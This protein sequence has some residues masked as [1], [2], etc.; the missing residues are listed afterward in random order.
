[1]KVFIHLTGGFLPDDRRRR[2]ALRLTVQ[3]NVAIPLDAH[4]DWLDDPSGWHCNVREIRF[5]QIRHGCQFSTYRVL[6]Y[7]SL[8]I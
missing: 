7:W 6:L 2:D 8:A 4:V 1:M 5:T 3:S